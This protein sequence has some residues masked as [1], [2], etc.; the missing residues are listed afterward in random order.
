MIIDN[1]GKLFGRINV[2]DLVLIIG[3]LFILLVLFPMGG[4]LMKGERNSTMEDNIRRNLEGSW[5]I[6]SDKR[7]GEKEREFGM[8]QSGFQEGYKVGVSKR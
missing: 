7:L 5:K 6:E 2:I 4:K 1:K 3:L 8:W